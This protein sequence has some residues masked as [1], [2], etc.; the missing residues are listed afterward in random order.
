[1]RD[2]ERYTAPG[3]F[4]GAAAVGAGYFAACVIGQGA[5][6]TRRKSPRVLGL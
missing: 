3:D 1:V 5:G 6:D 2:G 4:N